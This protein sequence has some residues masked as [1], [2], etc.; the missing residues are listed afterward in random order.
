MINPKLKKENL[1]LN[2]II[3]ANM[4]LVMDD[5]AVTFLEA[6]KEIEKC[7]GIKVDRT[8]MNRYIS[9][10][11]DNNFPLPV[12][13]AFC[14]CYHVSLSDIMSEKFKIT[15]EQA[16][17]DREEISRIHMDMEFSSG[18]DSLFIEDPTSPILENYIQPY[19][20]YYFSTVSAENHKENIG[21]SILSG[22]FELKEEGKKTKAILKI[23]TKTQSEDGKTNYKIYTGNAVVSLPFQSCNCIMQTDKG[24]FCFVIFRYSHL[25]YFKQ[26]CRLAE[27]LSLSSTPDKRYPVVH[28]MFL[29][30][31]ELSREDIE[32]IAP[33][34]QLNYSDILID[35]KS[36]F[37]MAEKSDAYACIIQELLRKGSTPVYRLRETDD[38]LPLLKKRMNS[39][40][41]NLFLNELRAYS[42]AY[43]FNKISPIADSNIQKLLESRGHYKKGGGKMENSDTAAI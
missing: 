38:I 32:L 7:S 39:K 16:S 10:P 17:D 33:Q 40:E 9:K 26:N 15:E 12:L 13:D 24:E 22:T 1:R 4:K 20:C 5:R 35:E 28:R 3:A 30:R 19:F 43:R 21:E 8:T 29:S 27:V 11:N 37:A 18:F 42:I 23:D 6:C 2:G 36:L 41:R 34:L 31:E 14:K 25:G